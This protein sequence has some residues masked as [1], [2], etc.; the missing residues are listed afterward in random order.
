MSNDAVAPAETRRRIE[1]LLADPSLADRGVRAQAHY[2]L[3]EVCQICGDPAAALSHL[4]EAV[5][6]DPVQTLSLIHI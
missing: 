3:W 6:L 5:A 1:R 2:L 4:A